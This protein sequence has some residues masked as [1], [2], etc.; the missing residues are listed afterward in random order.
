[1]QCASKAL[2]H[3]PLSPGQKPKHACARR[4]LEADVHF[5]KSMTALSDESPVQVSEL[6]VL[7]AAGCLADLMTP[8]RA[9]ES[10]DLK[11][12][13]TFVPAGPSATAAL[14]SARDSAYQ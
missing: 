4:S 6:L 5:A 13:V 2:A 12:G 1:M 8:V 11:C 9:Y 7:V 3:R 14:L 10:K